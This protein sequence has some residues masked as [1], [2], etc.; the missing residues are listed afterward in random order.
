VGGSFDVLCGNI[1]RAPVVWQ[2]VGMEWLHR[3]MKEPVKMAPRVFNEN[4]YLLKVVALQLLG[5][6][7]K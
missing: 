3:L 5:L 1:S 4:L 2:R 6:G 7:K